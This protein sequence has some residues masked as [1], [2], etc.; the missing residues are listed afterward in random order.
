MEVQRAKYANE[1]MPLIEDVLKLG[2]QIDHGSEISASDLNTLREPL[3]LV[4]DAAEELQQKAIAAFSLGLARIYFSKQGSKSDLAAAW[5]T[6]FMW[7]Y[8]KFEVTNGE[9]DPPLALKV[10][11]LLFNHLGPSDRAQQKFLL[12]WYQKGTTRENIRNR[13]R[14][15]GT[16]LP[17]RPG[18]GVL[19]SRIP[20]GER[21]NFDRFVLRSFALGVRQPLGERKVPTDLEESFAEYLTL[22]EFLTKVMMPK[23]DSASGDR[24]YTLDGEK[25]DHVTSLYITEL[26]FNFYYFSEEACECIYDGLLRRTMIAKAE[27][28]EAQRWARELGKSWDEPSMRPIGLAL[29]E[30][31]AVKYIKDGKDG[32]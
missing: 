22:P 20:K 18:E 12:E 10:A 29:V 26:P 23:E 11:V 1:W 31:A 14:E 19:I 21:E 13:N 8:E 32:E 17:E 15:E 27:I 5:L 3:I 9:F 2:W 4:Y 28:F 16:S 30:M 7:F 24:V 25:L 6:P